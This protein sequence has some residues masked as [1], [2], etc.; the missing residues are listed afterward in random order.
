MNSIHKQ[1]NY[2]PNDRNNVSTLGREMPSF[3][4]CT[5]VYAMKYTSSYSATPLQVYSQLALK[6]RNCCSTV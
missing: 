2:K 6:F 3:R 1:Q 4:N 5:L